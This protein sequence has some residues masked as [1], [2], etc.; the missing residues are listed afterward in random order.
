MPEALWRALPVCLKEPRGGHGVSS[1]SCWSPCSLL[2]SGCTCAEVVCVCLRVCVFE[3][4]CVPITRTKVS[5]LIFLT[6]SVCL[7]GPK[8][9]ILDMHLGTCSSW[10]VWC[11]CAGG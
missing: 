7:S 4:V 5:V 6:V 3:S 9:H 11:V 10:S 1:P 2:L 8:Q